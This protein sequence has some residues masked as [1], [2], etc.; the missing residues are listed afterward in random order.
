M[1]YNIHDLIHNILQLL[2]NHLQQILY[3]RDPRPFHLCEGSGAARLACNLKIV[4]SNHKKVC[5][6]MPL[7]ESFSDSFST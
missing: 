7:S 1:D 6:L 4:H 3:V 2:H 5:G